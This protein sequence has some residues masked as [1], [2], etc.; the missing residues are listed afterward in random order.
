[1]PD[2]EPGEHTLAEGNDHLKA[3]GWRIGAYPT[4]VRE[5]LVEG[6]GNGY[7]HKHLAWLGR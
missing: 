1:M 2:D 5:D 4:S 7:V 6:Q 3:Y